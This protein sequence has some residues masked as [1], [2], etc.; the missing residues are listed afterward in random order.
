MFVVSFKSSSVFKMYGPPYILSPKDDHD[1]R[2]TRRRPGPSSDLG[3][4]TVHASSPFLQLPTE[5]HLAIS[6]HLGFY[7]IYALRLSNRYFASILPP[8]EERSRILPEDVD[9]DIDFALHFEAEASYLAR[10]YGLAACIDCHCLELS[11]TMYCHWFGS[12]R[13]TSLMRRRCTGAEP[14]IDCS[15]GMGHHEDEML[16]YDTILTEP[17][18][19]SKRLDAPRTS[20]SDS[21]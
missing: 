9:E 1:Y 5:M 4:T 16:D 6:S 7:D 2:R 17:S 15:C 18:G 12:E 3:D 13:G 8:L 11:W 20:P 14:Q 19:S 10:S 21:E